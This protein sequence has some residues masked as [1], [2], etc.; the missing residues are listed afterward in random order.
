MGY[1]A[2]YRKWRPSTFDEVRGQDH[3]VTTLKNQIASG[4]IGH[5]YLFC[6]TRGT[7][8]TSIAKIF[9]RAVNCE[10]PHN[11]NPC[12]ECAA[13]RAIATGASMN[14]VEIDAASNNGVDNIRQIRDEVEYS[15]AD[16]K[17]RVYIIDEVHMLS[18]GAFNALLK[19]LEE[20]PSYVIFILATTEAHKIPIT[21]LSRCQRYDFR[22]IDGETIAGRLRQMA[23]AEGIDVEDQ[24]LRYVAKKGDGSL[25]DSISLFDQCVAFYYGEKL[26]FER[27]LDVLGAVDNEVYSRF[28]RLLHDKN[29]GQ[30]LRQVEELI[31]QGRDLGQFVS[32]FVWYLR[33]LLLAQ[34]GE[35]NG[36]LL[37]MSGEDQAR[38]REDAAMI[39]EETAMRWI[40]VL[41][42]TMNQ[43]RYSTAKRVLLEITLIKLTRPAMEDNM[44]SVMQ[45][46]EDLERG[47]AG[48]ATALGLA[49]SG[50]EMDGYGEGYETADSYGA[51]R[52]TAAKPISSHAA[53]DPNALLAALTPELLAQALA[54]AGMM[55]ATGG[56]QSG[57]GQMGSSAPATREPQT[58]VLPPA[59]LNELRLLQKDWKEIISAVGATAKTTLANV[60]LEP[61]DEGQ[62]MLIFHDQQDHFMGSRPSMLQ[63][64]ENYIAT[65]Y[66]I[67]VHLQAKLVAQNEYTRKRYVTEE[68]LKQ[69]FNVD[70]IME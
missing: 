63:N 31:L 41:S 34:T 60:K 18:T 16:G 55:P 43:M 11:G 14:V 26:T 30:C 2:L 13:C 10:H 45:R 4:R 7:G 65:A 22:R 24:A 17:F 51:G 9:A 49:D 48:S 67:Q 29:V 5:A 36:D 21:V 28:L 61:M 70:I 57:T 46:L 56:A 23:D 27:V 42:E 25:R 64:V 53:M 38:L 12:G 50:Y 33:S 62:L 68:E 44:D 20:P 37:D 40:R 52:R 32:D 3:I 66:Q 15:P 1:T 54:A 58:V 6:G 69:K 8:K 47:G 35:T 19:T 59:Q 39:S